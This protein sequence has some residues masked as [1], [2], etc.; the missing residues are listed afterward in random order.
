MKER[1]GERWGWIGGWLGGFIWIIILSIVWLVKGKLY[2]GLAGI[3]LF[4]LAITFI[5]T[6]SPWKHPT[7]RYW[8]LLLPLFLVL[9]F[10]AALF[11]LSEGGL[12]AAGL[13]WWSLIYL[14]PCL[15]PFATMGSRSWKDGDN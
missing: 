8:K 4:S 7:T 1:K 11:I 13:N 10:S 14:A 2:I 5:F 3:C 9:I 12:K 6:F 15:I